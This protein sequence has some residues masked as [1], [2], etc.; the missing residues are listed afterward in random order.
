ML[1]LLKQ[2]DV[3]KPVVKCY[4]LQG[5]EVLDGPLALAKEIIFKGHSTYFCKINTSG[6]EG[7]HLVNP[8]SMYADESVTVK[9]T[10]NK[11][12]GKQHQE[13]KEV[14]QETFTLYVRYLSSRSDVHYRQA[15][16]LAINA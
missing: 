7:G 1:H 14:S 6:I 12:T 9:N 15:E 2:Q 8:W 3:A 11:L 4:G 10:V 5:E 16:R 13:Y